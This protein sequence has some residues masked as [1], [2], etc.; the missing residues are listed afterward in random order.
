M[1]RGGWI[2]VNCDDETLKAVEAFSRHRRI[3]RA[4]A[5]GL[6]L[7]AG[8]AALKPVV[9]EEVAEERARIRARLLPE[10]G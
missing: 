10:Q 8:V 2:P 9:A 4:A 1:S 3:G 6:L 5:A 7:E